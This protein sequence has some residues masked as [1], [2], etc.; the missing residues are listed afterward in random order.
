[1]ITCQNPLND[2]DTDDTSSE[3]GK[4]EKGR[5]EG[6]ELAKP[7]LRSTPGVVWRNSLGYAKGR[8]PWHCFTAE[9]LRWASWGAEL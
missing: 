1:M 5:G 6:S 3:G 8:K 2:Q 9:T 4:K 7:V